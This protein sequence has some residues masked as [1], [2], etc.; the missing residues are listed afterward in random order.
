MPR[1]PSR[2][3]AGIRGRPAALGRRA[4]RA[5]GRRVQHLGRP[6]T[7]SR[8][9]TRP[10][11]SD[12]SHSETRAAEL[13]Q[14]AR[15]RARALAALPQDEARA[16]F[17]EALVPV[18]TGSR[19]RRKRSPN[20]S[21]L[22]PSGRSARSWT[23]GWPRSGDSGQVPAIADEV[24]PGRARSSGALSASR[25]GSRSRRSRGRL[26]QPAPRADR[27]MPGSLACVEAGDASG[28]R[29]QF[30]EADAPGVN[31]PKA[32]GEPRQTCGP[33]PRPAERSPTLPRIVAE[34]LPQGSLVCVSVD[35]DTE[36]RVH[37]PRL[38]RVYDIGL[39]DR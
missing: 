38:R 1:V 29:R 19:R 3:S 30:V 11:R 12:A 6:R 34:V 39:A 35:Y 4:L 22:L 2:S 28:A 17:D 13:G 36:L 33:A 7:R 26:A 16:A 8:C 27:S 5:A 14:H 10:W 37:D 25:D 20:R 15:V 9:S 24:L 18:A 21:G 31:C 32:A 23:A